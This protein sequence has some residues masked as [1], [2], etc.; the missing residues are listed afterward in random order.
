MRQ[1]VVAVMCAMAI[2]VVACGGSPQATATSASPSPSQPTTSPTATSAAALL[3][4]TP[5]ATL[6]AT[7]SQPTSVPAATATRQPTPTATR[8]PATA[9]PT[10]ARAA[11]SRTTGQVQGVTF[12]VSDGSK[13]TFTVRE[14]LAR[15][16]LPNDA[17][18]S[19][20]AL[21][22]QVHLDGRTSSVQINLQQ[23][24]SDQRDRDQ[25][26]RGTM[27]RN[28]PTATFTLPALIPLP[29]GFP[30][31]KEV[32]TK[33]TG[34]LRIKSKDVPLTFDVQARDDGNVVY[35]LGKTTFTW[36]Q[37]GLATPSSFNVVSIADEVKVEML[38]ALKPVFD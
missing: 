4:P 3:P 24:S 35:M 23:L 32:N 10:T 33:V 26:I 30:D 16:P 13:A 17:V 37:L 31:G 34:T 15:V 5:T 1:T 19:T 29:D 38:L 18:V 6:G 8:P 12:V 25:Y 14:Q 27:F 9:T 20:S 21:T 11:Q 2:A 36:A 28:G 7:V 22:G